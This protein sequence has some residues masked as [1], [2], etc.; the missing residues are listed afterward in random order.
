MTNSYK[1]NYKYLHF[2]QVENPGR[3]TSIWECRNNRSQ[4]TLGL[5]KWYGPWRQ[6]CYYPTVQAVYSPGCMDD[7]A[8]FIR[9]LK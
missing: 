3:K 9:Q 8:H 4:A 7:M 2:I 6:Y 5:V 1:Y